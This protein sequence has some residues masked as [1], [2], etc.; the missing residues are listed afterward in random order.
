[1]EI[2][3]LLT[4]QEARKWV[5]EKIRREVSRTSFYNWR[6]FLKMVKSHYSLD[7]V[8]SLALFGGYVKKGM[9][10][11]NA[12]SACKCQISMSQE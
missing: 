2:C 3:V 12:L 5:A 4:E 9:S 8:E 7:E 6:V 1:M 10:L 11:E